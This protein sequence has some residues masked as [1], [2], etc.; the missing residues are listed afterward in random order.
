M[1]VKALKDKY[2]QSFQKAQDERK[3]GF[4]TNFFQIRECKEVGDKGNLIRIVRPLYFTDDIIEPWLQYK[5]WNI[6]FSGM[7]YG[8]D[9]PAP[10][11]FGQP[12]PIFDLR[13]Q[14][15]AD[16]D[17]DGYKFKLRNENIAIVVDMETDEG[18]AKGPQIWKFPDA[19]KLE[20]LDFLSDDDQE[21]L[22][23]DLTENGINIY[24]RRDGTGKDT[25]YRV[26]PGKVCEVPNYP[27]IMA[28]ANKL[29][30][31]NF[32][33]LDTPET[34]IGAL[35]GEYDKDEARAARK[36][37]DNTIGRVVE[38]HFFGQELA[39]G[40]KDDSENPSEAEES[41][42]KKKPT[43]SSAPTRT[44]KSPSEPE[45]ELLKAKKKVGLYILTESG[46]S[47][48]IIDVDE[49]DN[50]V[51]ILIVQGEHPEPFG[52]RNDAGY[53]LDDKPVKPKPKYKMADAP[54][55]EAKAEPEPE[56]AEKTEPEQP[57]TEA[58]E[59]L[60]EP[61]KASYKDR[62]KKYHDS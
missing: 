16:N 27:A 37:R 60:S 55:A 40:H 47:G 1:D 11:F 39:R 10:C 33:P 41:K 58:N 43:T 28:E 2:K 30:L 26:K 44:T 45:S 54:A 53:S 50:G 5:K 52:V 46:Y 7:K 24:V 12:D 19:A 25:R 62:L 6:P 49:D 42:G 51:P 38:V 22:P 57:K 21:H 9:L 4:E 8:K 36:E 61:A 20:L 13:E 15:L 17:Q 34:L 48:K 59:K 18:F 32:I 3:S 31:T 23:Y 56:G 35:E 14:L 29:Y